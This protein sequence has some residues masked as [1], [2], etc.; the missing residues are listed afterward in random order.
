MSVLPKPLARARGAGAPT[1][2]VWQGRA[3]IPG[4]SSFL[5]DFG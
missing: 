5:S 3:L 4:L 1:E 2:Q